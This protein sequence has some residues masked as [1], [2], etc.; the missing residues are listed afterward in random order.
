MTV[1]AVVA[2]WSLAHSGTRASEN[3]PHNPKAKEALFQLRSPPNA[4]LKR[5]KW[6]PILTVR[7]PPVSRS[8]CLWDRGDCLLNP[9]GTT[10]QNSFMLPPMGITHNL[11]LLVPV[12]IFGQ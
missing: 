4:L 3:P 10:E 1:F 2:V 6:E 9:W 12:L 8:P 11:L 5:S 7:S